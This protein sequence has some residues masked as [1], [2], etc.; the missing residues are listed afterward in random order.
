MT[1]SKQARQACHMAASYQLLSQTFFPGASPVA[2]FFHVL[3]RE[4]SRSIILL[5]VLLFT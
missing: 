4:T 3:R 2:D 5:G 1:V